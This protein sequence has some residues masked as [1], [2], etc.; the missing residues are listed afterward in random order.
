LPP[1]S[2]GSTQNPQ[3]LHVYVSANTG[4]VLLMANR[5]R[6]ADPAS[7][8]K[9][10]A[11]TTT[12]AAAAAPAD[13]AA[14]VAAS[15]ANPTGPPVP[16]QTAQPPS[17]KPA[18][19]HAAHAAKP[20]AAKGGVRAAHAPS[21]TS[22]S[23]KKDRYMSL[24]RGQSLYS[25]EVPLNTALGAVRSKGGAYQLVD[26]VHNAETYDMRNKEDAFEGAGAVEALFHDKDNQWWVALRARQ[27][28]QGRGRQ[29]EQRR[30]RKEAH[31]AHQAEKGALRSSAGR[32]TPLTRPRPSPTPP[33][34]GDGTTLDRQSAAVDA[35][36]GA[37]TTLA[38]YK[39]V[40]GRNGVDGRGSRMRSRVHLSKGYDNAYCETVAAGRGLGTRLAGRRGAL[41]VGSAGECSAQTAA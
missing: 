17:A 2:T 39:D 28:R 16:V 21:A 18:A 41:F 10:A 6:N 34:R 33:P 29:R 11:A 38:Y 5:I 35:H 15:A 12:F 26:L 13:P 19:G 30:G 4:D 8:T 22:S 36:Y 1:A 14:A 23:P 24:G 27:G 37:S 31:A 40:H 9:A 3:E 20:G 32:P 7:A 25:G